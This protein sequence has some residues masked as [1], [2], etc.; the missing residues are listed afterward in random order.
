MGSRPEANTQPALPLYPSL[1]PA[2][3]LRA[4]AM[5]MELGSVCSS[6]FCFCT[7]IEVLFLCSNDDDALHSHTPLWTRHEVA[8]ST[9]VPEVPTALA[10]QH[11]VPGHSQPS[12]PARIDDLPCPTSHHTSRPCHPRDSANSRGS[13]DVRQGTGQVPVVGSID[14]GIPLLGSVKK[15]FLPFLVL[16]P[17]A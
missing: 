1:G 8:S 10:A 13:G 15:R 7:T 17:G 4:M 5:A 12:Q 6:G 3:R 9:Y 16:L 14:R 2:L 11:H